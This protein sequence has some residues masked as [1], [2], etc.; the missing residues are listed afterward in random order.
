MSTPQRIHGPAIVTF[1]GVSYYFKS[2][3]KVAVKSTRSKI[4]VDAWGQIAEVIKHRVVTIT[5]TPAGCVRSGDIAGQ[6]PY[7]PGNVGSSV[8]GASDVPLVVQTINDGATITWERAA[9]TKYAPMLLS[10]AGGTIYKGD[11]EF[12]CLMASSFTLTSA[13]AFKSITSTSFADTTFDQS[14]VRMSQ[15]VAAWGSN[16][17]YN[18]MISQDG[19]SFEPAIACENLEVDNFGIIDMV[20]KSVAGTCKFKPANLTEAQLDTLVELQGSGAW[21][22]GQTIGDGGNNLVITGSHLTATL[23]G[24]GAVDYDLMYATGKLRAGEV[25]FGAA[26]TFTSGV[27]NAVFT[28]SVS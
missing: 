22:P 13:T 27:P 8:F 21:L 20:L 15:Y 24:A 6:M 4:D 2:G 18:S 10:A 14:K 5:G 17:P 16:S 28:F 3:I 12:T 9:I 19:F 1:N 11:M 23:V 26:T 25:A 7:G